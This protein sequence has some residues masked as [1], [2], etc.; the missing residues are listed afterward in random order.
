MVMAQQPTKR[1]SAS[2]SP[3]RL[4]PAPTTETAPRRPSGTPVLPLGPG[5]RFGRLH[6]GGQC[7]N[8]GENVL[9]GERGWIDRTDTEVLCTACWP[10]LLVG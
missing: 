7:V 1:V 8:C 5:S 10:P 2:R 6:W 9:P 4:V 3:V